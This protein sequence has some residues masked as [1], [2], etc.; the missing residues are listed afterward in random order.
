MPL[1]ASVEFIVT[2]LGLV[3][4]A[5]CCSEL[6]A[7][8]YAPAEDKFTEPRNATQTQAPARK[9]FIF[10]TAFY[11]T[12]TDNT[13]SSASSCSSNGGDVAKARPR[14]GRGQTWQPWRG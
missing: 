7:C 5:S 12:A 10:I 11:Q 13:I 1:D 3:S 8:R 6:D 9:L 14:I 2:I 4:A